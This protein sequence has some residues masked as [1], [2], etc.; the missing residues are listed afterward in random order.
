MYVCKLV[1]L[2]WCTCT[3]VLG[4]T[5][6]SIAKTNSMVHLLKEAWTE[7]SQERH[8]LYPTPPHEQHIMEEF[9]RLITEPIQVD[10]DDEFDSDSEVCTPMATVT[11]VKSK[12][13]A[14]LGEEGPNDPPFCDP[15]F[16]TQVS[17]C[18][19]YWIYT[20][21]YCFYTI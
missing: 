3:Y 21:L 13:P 14:L 6:L 7:A 18:T 15:V 12:S 5:A 20:Y 10:H 19:P 4:D 8:A 16:V 1:S 9:D 2:I 11:M 17:G